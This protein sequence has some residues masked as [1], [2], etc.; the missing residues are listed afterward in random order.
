MPQVGLLPNGRKFI[1]NRVDT[2]ECGKPE[3]QALN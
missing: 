3:I 2:V 1:E